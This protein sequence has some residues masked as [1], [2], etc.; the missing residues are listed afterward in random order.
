MASS[1]FS[2]VDILK[3]WAS[4]TGECI[5]S[6]DVV[7]R[8]EMLGLTLVLVLKAAWGIQMAFQTNAA[9]Y[10]CLIA[11]LDLSAFRILVEQYFLSIGMQGG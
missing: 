1:V 5:F 8:L 10:L 2:G 11:R 7:K 9:S 6:L 4:F 3:C